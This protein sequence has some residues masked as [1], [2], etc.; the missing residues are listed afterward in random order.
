MH[1]SSLA[2]AGLLVAGPAAAA[3]NPPPLGVAREAR[4]ADA[5]SASEGRAA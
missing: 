1:F 2:L 3:N 5:R 4:G